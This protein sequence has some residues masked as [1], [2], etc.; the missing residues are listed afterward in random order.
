MQFSFS[1]HSLFP[2]PAL[3]ETLVSL[4]EDGEEIPKWHR[5]DEGLLTMTNIH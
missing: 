2:R 4:G 1:Y 3:E 5:K